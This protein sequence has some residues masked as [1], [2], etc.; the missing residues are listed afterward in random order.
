MSI[1]KPIKFVL[2]ALALVLAALGVGQIVLPILAA[3]ALK[4]KVAKYG[5][6]EAASVS[7]I[8]AIQLLW[9]SAGSAQVRVGR[10]AISPE[11]IVKL[12]LESGS[13]GDLNVTARSVEVLDP[14]LGAKPFVV[15]DAQITKRG[16][17]ISASA[18]LSRQ[19]LAAALPGGL[20]AEVLEEAADGVAIRARSD[21]F[22]F[23]AHV[24]GLIQA[25]EGK[26]RLSANHPLLAGLGRVT[27]FSNP[28]VHVLSLAARPQVQP[29]R[30]IASGSPNGAG[31]ASAW[32][33]SVEAELH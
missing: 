3:K 13:V 23:R 31:D 11:E 27:L 30:R 21:L 2:G 32:R 29:H 1:G 20:E 9:G 7:A 6:V 16:S 5:E 15:T 22:G 4:A 8:P 18:V 17:V 19:H 10:L 26:V 12:L 24:D 33:L 14:G 25:S 28:R